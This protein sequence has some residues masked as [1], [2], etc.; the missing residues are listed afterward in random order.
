MPAAGTHMLTRPN[1]LLMESNTDARN[2]SS[3][4]LPLYGYATGR[5]A[6]ALTSAATASIP[7]PMSTIAT[8]RTPR[9]ARVRATARPMPLA[10]PVMTATLSANS[11]EAP[12]NV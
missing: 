7:S 9:A 1:W 3:V 8:A 10:A 6:L 4:V 12:G 2:A 5:P 11:M